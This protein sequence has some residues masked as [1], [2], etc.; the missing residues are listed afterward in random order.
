MN[1]NGLSL[2]DISEKV[3]DKLWSF[4]N[5]A[6]AVVIDS[7]VIAAVQ[8]CG[9]QICQNIGAIESEIRKK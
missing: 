3:H 5:W 8:W 1:C 4:L 7:F 2:L 9:N 6:I